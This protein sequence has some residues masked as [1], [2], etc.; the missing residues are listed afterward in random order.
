[1][2]IRDRV[3]QIRVTRRD[4]RTWRDAAAAART[5]VS[6]LIRAA[7]RARLAQPPGQGRG[8]DGGKNS[9]R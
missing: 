8:T 9:T 6:D 1:M 5:T 3:V 4:H 7:V 2:T